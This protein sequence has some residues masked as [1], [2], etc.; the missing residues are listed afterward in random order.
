MDTG[1]DPAN[2]SA[3][4]AAALH[5]FALDTTL[6]RLA[7]NRSPAAIERIVAKVHA[8]APALEGT[9]PQCS[10]G[11]SP[12]CLI[13]ELIPIQAI[14][15]AM[16]AE[17]KAELTE[18]A[19]EK[20]CPF[21]IENGCLLGKS[22]PL[23]CRRN[24]ENREIL[25]AI[26]L[27]H[28]TGL[29]ASGLDHHRVDIAQA[30]P[31]MLT[32]PDWIDQYARGEHTFWE[33]G[34]FPAFRDFVA[35]GAR[36]LAEKIEP[37]GAPANADEAFQSLAAL[38]EIPLPQALAFLKQDSTVNRIASLRL[39]YACSSEDEIE[40]SRAEYLKNLRRVAGG[41]VNPIEALNALR[42][43]DTYPLAYQGREVRSILTE[44]G[45]TLINPI[46]RSALPDLAQPIQPR[47]RE[48]KY[49]VGYLSPTLRY[50]NGSYWSLGWIRNQAEDIETFAFGTGPQNDAGFEDFREAADHA[51]YLPGDITET[52]RFIKSLNLDVLI[53]TDIGMSSG[54]YFYSAMRLAP[55]QATAWGHPV[56]SGLPTIDY[57]LSSQLMEPKNGD[58]HYREKLVRLP[59]SGLYLT[60]REPSGIP[61]TREDFG[62]PE[63]FLAVMPHSPIKLVPKEDELFAK[64][65]QTLENPIVFIDSMFPV[66]NP[67]IKARLEKAGVRQQWLERLNGPDF[68]RVIELSDLVLDIPAWNGGN[69][70]VE[71][72]AVDKPIVTMPGEF[73]RGRHGLAFLKQANLE[74]LIAKD[75]NDYIRIA[76]D[77]DL[78]SRAMKNAN[79][80]GPC[81]DIEAVRGLDAWIRQ[82]VDSL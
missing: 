14:L 75:Q 5:Q 78:Q 59:G 45:D 35:E 65:S 62:L 80:M 61:K 34:M 18:K 11:F 2:Q 53:F 57:Y 38:R 60:P 9:C 79:P 23:N 32:Q 72:I 4:R 51:Y 81:E 74:P 70:T 10:D 27:G 31:L 58:D 3:A 43:F 49:R 30:L 37:T 76:T 36:M 20:H 25:A 19:N 69:V 44:V 52:A 7:A 42:L 66:A 55:I 67:V 17:Q 46:I 71:T 47:K 28:A 48:G 56:T 68:R 41:R 50:H 26:E 16:P 33:C 6:R 22:K 29:C 63:G 82:T 8:A 54:S 12:A 73:M 13:S 15:N 64:L 40:S 39:P 77:R 24:A 21:L 1:P